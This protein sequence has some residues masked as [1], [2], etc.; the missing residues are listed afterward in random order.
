MIPSIFTSSSRSHI[1][2]SVSSTG[3]IFPSTTEKL[4]DDGRLEKKDYNSLVHRTTDDIGIALEIWKMVCPGGDNAQYVTL[5]QWLILCKQISIVEVK[6]Q[7]NMD[8]LYETGHVFPVYLFGLI[9]TMKFLRPPDI[10]Y[11]EISKLDVDIVGWKHIGDGLQ[12]HIIY[13]IRYA[14]NMKSFARREQIVERRYNDFKV[15]NSFLSKYK[16]HILPQLPWKLQL[17]HDEE[18]VSQRSHELFI[19]LSYITKHDCFRHSFELKVFLEASE[20]GFEAFRALVSKLEQQQYQHHHTNETVNDITLCTES[21]YTHIHS[22]HRHSSVTYSNP[23]NAIDMENDIYD[24]NI[25]NENDMETDVSGDSVVLVDT[26]PPPTPTPTSTTTIKTSR[27]MT[28]P[29]TATSPPTNVTT[30]TTSSTIVGAGA[31]RALVAVN[32]LWNTVHKQIETSSASL[33]NLPG[34]IPLP[35]LSSTPLSLS[36]QSLSQSKPLSLSHTVPGLAD[37]TLDPGVDRMYQVTVRLG[38]VCKSLSTLLAAEAATRYELSR[39]GYYLSQLAELG[40]GVDSS[41]DGMLRDTS[42]DID[43]ISSAAQM[44]GVLTHLSVIASCSHS[45]QRAVMQRSQI[46]TNIQSNQNRLYICR[47]AVDTARSSVR[48][49]LM[50]PKASLDL[51]RVE[52]SVEC[53]KRELDD[54][55]D[56]FRKDIVWF[57]GLQSFEIQQR[58]LGWVQVRTACHLRE[59]EMWEHLRDHLQRTM[60]DE[61]QQQQLSTTEGSQDTFI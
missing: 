59:R 36:S 22:P 8:L 27:T 30:T 6:G 10:I 5:E 21:R 50:L 16:G 15:L 43:A 35:T 41:L 55:T 17:Q 3:H 19:F 53:S 4:N 9:K 51:S 14:T 58:L 60:I 12:K 57:D 46:H 28:M 33:H 20:K 61:Q 37:S 26:P 11:N 49:G 47:K 31:A 40:V 38:Q 52:A 23:D 45:L 44:S 32:A 48:S 56:N 25:D 24:M 29:I 34:H 54:V 39:T 2:L 1:M 18:F 7:I 42:A 13:I